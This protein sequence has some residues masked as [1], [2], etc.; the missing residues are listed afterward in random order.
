MTVPFNVALQA[1]KDFKGVRYYP[2]AHNDVVP[3]VIEFILFEMPFGAKRRQALTSI[4]SMT[5]GILVNTEG[6]PST[7]SDRDLKLMLKRGDVV[8]INESPSIGCKNKSQWVRFNPT[9]P[10]SDGT[11]NPVSLMQYAATIIEK[12]MKNARRRAQNTLAIRLGLKSD[13]KLRR[14][15]D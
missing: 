10:S 1:I 12:E 11:I 8:L 4:I 6:H 3:K 13:I 15:K 2:G 7:R 14:K 5:G 9:I